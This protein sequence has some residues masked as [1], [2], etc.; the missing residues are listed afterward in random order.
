MTAADWDAAWTTLALAALT[1]PLLLLIA[2]PIAWRLAFAR[3]RWKSVAEALVVLPL[4]LPPTV[5]GFY[6]LLALGPSGW[7]GATGVPLLFTFPGLVVASCVHSLP[8]AVQP[9]QNA[10]ES[11]GRARLEAAASLNAAPW[12][13]FVN[14]ALPLAARGYVTAGVLTFAHTLGE[15]GVLW[16]VGGAVP[17]RTRILS[18]AIYEHVERLDYAAAG[19]LSLALMAVSFTVLLAVY[20]LNRR[21]RVSVAGPR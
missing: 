11:V 1:A 15:F 14:V 2:T 20:V 13:A 8:F 6:M 5:L 21:A 18:V 19:R 7:E 3:G 10:F 17:G 12:D 16:M 9:L 4:V